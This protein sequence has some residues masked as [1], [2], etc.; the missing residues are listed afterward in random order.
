MAHPRAAAPM[1][2][3]ACRLRQSA[4]KLNFTTA[5]AEAHQLPSCQRLVRRA[6]RV[7][8][9]TAAQ[10]SRHHSTTST[11]TASSASS[12]SEPP[13]SSVSPEEVAHFNA[14]ASSWW[15][16]F[17]PSRLLHQMNPLR[18]DFIRACIRDAAFFSPATTSAQPMDDLLPRTF[19]DI[20]CGGGI[21][22]ESAA[23]LP[24]TT[25]VTAID[26]SA[27]VLAVARAHA[28]RDPVV[29]E[30]LQY[31][32]M[33]VEDL[34]AAEAASQ[35]LYDIVTLFEVLEHVA[36]DPGAFL[37]RCGRLLKPG[38]W[39]V[40]STMARTWTSWLTTVVAAEDVLGIVPRG[41]HD[42]NKYINADELEA[43]F[44]PGAPAYAT[45]TW[46]NARFQG[47]A[48]VPGLGWKVVPG[49]E[50][51]GNYFFAIQ[52]ADTSG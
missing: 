7:S 2:R 24:T 49:G 45:A 5:T 11:S 52:K 43:F 1:L 32:Q 16:P 8:T 26:P 35:P 25:S 46:Q 36:T 4:S 50:K 44:A 29:F 48:Y 39:L 20:G 38:G 12:A 40:L 47:V 30:R 41:T 28:R 10:C 21:F 51:L 22:A 37:D 17:G 31:R 34:A 13:F 19:L 27:E 3:R 42:W 14:L 23:R 9:A 6:S 33:S 15:D 18:H